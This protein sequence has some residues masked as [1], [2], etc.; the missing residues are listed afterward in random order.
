MLNLAN[1]MPALPPVK[2]PNGTV[3]QIVPL[4]AHM[5]EQFKEIRAMQKAIEAGEDIDDAIYVDAVDVLLQAV[6]PTATPDDL[7]SFGFR[8]EIKLAPILAAAGRVDDVLYAL[9]AA[10]AGNGGNVEAL[11]ESIQS[12]TPAAP[13]P[14]TAAPSDR[15]G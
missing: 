5:Y 4:S 12:T 11:L 7:A 6:L 9:E 8:V 1:L 14:D 13:S 15:I 10:T 3:H 2:L